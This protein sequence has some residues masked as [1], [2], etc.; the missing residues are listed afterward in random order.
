MSSKN[1]F[2]QE[3]RNNVNHLNYY[4]F[5]KAFTPEEIIKIREIGD[6]SQI[7]EN[8]QHPYT[9]SLIA[10]V[11]EPDPISERERLVE[12]KLSKLKERS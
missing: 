8:P 7:Y 11:P 5:T 12:R 9:Q 4:Y 1:Y 10:I 6:R 3:Q 2:L